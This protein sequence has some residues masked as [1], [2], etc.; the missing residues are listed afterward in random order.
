MKALRFLAAHQPAAVLEIPCPQPGPGEV[1][2]KIGAAGVCHSDLHLLSHGRPGGA[3]QFTLGHENAGWVAQL[4]ANVSGLKE[5]DAVAVYGAWGCGHCGACMLSAE[6]YCV[7]RPEGLPALFG[8]AG[9]DGGMAEY[10]LV[11]SVRHLVPIGRLPPHIAAPLTDAGLTPFHAITRANSKLRPGATVAVI[12]V[13]GLGHMALQILGAMSSCRVVA[14]DVMDVKLELA[15]AVGAHETHNLARARD[16]STFERFRG[17]NACDVVLDCV[18]S[19]DTIGAAVKIA[20]INGI[21]MVLGLAGGIYP[22]SKAQLPW[23][24]TLSF[25]YWGTRHELCEV[26]ALAQ[27]GEI[28]PHV[29][30]HALAQGPDVLSQL[31]SG[32]VNGR[33]VLVP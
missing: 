13:G 29:V 10:M 20:K 21:V 31:E 33:A 30:C 15:K 1:L 6:N 16:E 22:F 23:G 25:P 5:G 3:A 17:A 28:R 11:P 14:F 26:I 27:S 2:I 19:D 18:G 24:T 8:G 4:G 7:N 9:I 12:G 32:Q